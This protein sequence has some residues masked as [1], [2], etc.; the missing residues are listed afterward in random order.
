MPPKSMT[1]YGSG[2]ARDKNAVVSI[3]LHSINHKY[4]EI[5]LSVPKH[6]SII[7][8]SIRK[9]IASWITRGRISVT[10]MYTSL[11]HIPSKIVTV[12]QVLVKQYIDQIA[13]L[14]KQ[15][16]LSGD[17][18]VTAL[19]SMQDIFRVEK[20]DPDE[21]LLGALVEAALRKALKK[22]IQKRAAEG[23][24]LARQMEKQIHTILAAIQAIKKRLPEVNKEYMVRLKKRMVEISGSAP[25]EEKILREVAVFAE[26]SD[27]TEEIDRLGYHIVSIKSLLKET[28]PMG[29]SLDFIVQEAHR[30][31]NTLGVKAN[32]LDVLQHVIT[33][34]G[35][36][37][38]IREQI[39]NIE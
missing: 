23:K 8:D 20:N 12:D 13:V 11:R 35:E 31:I 19:F 38:K 15:F 10:M 5:A 22:L 37:E 14:K 34:K 29:K 17:M 26:K 28:K 7:E 2:E 32:D 24:M 39:Q 30:E 16:G 1:G 27:V 3:E 18:N 25:N 9:E 36:L 21:G 33:I 4:R 6:M